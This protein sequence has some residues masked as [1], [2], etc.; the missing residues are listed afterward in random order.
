MSRDLDLQIAETI[1]AEIDSHVG[2]LVNA[3]LSVRGI[4]PEVAGVT[5]QPQ[6]VNAQLMLAVRDLES[7][8]FRLRRAQAFLGR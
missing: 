6:E 8:A 4:T 7:A 1:S 5:S 2:V 3:E